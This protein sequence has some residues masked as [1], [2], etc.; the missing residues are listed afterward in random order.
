MGAAVYRS[1]PP[2][3][4]RVCRLPAC[5]RTAGTS[6]WFIG[7]RTTTVSLSSG[8]NPIAARRK[9]RRQPG[10][11][12]LRVPFPGPSLAREPSLR[13]RLEVPGADAAAGRRRHAPQREAVETGRTRV[14][15]VAATGV[16]GAVVTEA[17]QQSLTTT[18]SDT[19]VVQPQLVWQ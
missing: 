11:C 16:V 6:S 2:A 1:L 15:P 9:K 19:T 17:T 18:R 3:T 7:I 8:S 12:R 14:E 10:G 5:T 4:G 13:A